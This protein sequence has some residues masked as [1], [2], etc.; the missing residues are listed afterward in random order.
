MTAQGLAKGIELAER[1]AEQRA[2]D[3][4][5]HHARAAA[6]RRERSGERAISPKS[7]MAAIASSSDEA[8]ARLKDFLEKRGKKV[9]R[10]ELAEAMRDTKAATAPLRPVRLG[11]ADVL[12][13]RK[14]DG[15]I[16]PALAAPARRLSRTS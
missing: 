13:E 15:T 12:L 1:I 4:L 3:Q 5:R 16:Y 2:A 6:H 14:A 8:K 9:L 11:P 7:L 10:D